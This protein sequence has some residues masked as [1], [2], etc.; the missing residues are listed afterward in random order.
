MWNTFKAELRHIFL[1]NKWRPWEWLV[2]VLIPFFYG[3]FYMNA[4]WNPFGHTEN[5]RVAVVNLSPQNITAKKLATDL[6]K[7]N[8]IKAGTNTYKFNIVDASDVYKTEQEAKNAVETDKYQAVIIID[9]EFAN[10]W[11]DIVKAVAHGVNVLLTTNPNDLSKAIE[12]ARKGDAANGIVGLDQIQGQLVTFYNSA[13]Y[14]YLAGEMTNFGAGLSQ[15]EL[16]SIFPSVEDIKN[17]LAPLGA[18]AHLVATDPNADK[19]IRDFMD[20]LTRIGG[21]EKIIEDSKSLGGNI[22]TYGFGLAPYFMCIAL[23][24]GALVMTFLIKNERHAKHHRTFKTYFGKS[25]A[26]VLTG[27]L[28]ALVLAT[29]ITLQGV[30]LGMNQWMLFLL[31]M[32]ISTIFT[33]TVQGIAFSFRYGDFGEFAA[34]ILLVVQ[35]VSASGTFPVDM[36]AGIFKFLHPII[37]FTYSIDALRESMFEPDGLVIL[38]DL[39]ILLIFPAIAMTISLLINWRFDMRTRVKLPDGHEYDSF[40]IHLG[41][42]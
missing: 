29:A 23:W 37:P 3:F 7:D 20:V 16:K 11:E 22:N 42:H 8:S 21:G 40:E 39:A 27:W 9:G 30:D 19:T 34:V 24:A 4:Y 36:Q 14:N 15:L 28:Q 1:S 25:I 41:D 5:L 35:L 13:K 26:W 10:R 32:F 18:V 31:A 6:Q 33:L 38:K 2:V 12:A 17:A